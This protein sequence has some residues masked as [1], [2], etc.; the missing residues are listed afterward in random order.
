M[1]PQRK[2]ARSMRPSAEPYDIP[3]KYSKKQCEEMMPLYCHMSNMKNCGAEVGS[4]I[5]EFGINHDMTPA[6]EIL[7][8][9]LS[10]EDD[11][12][13]RDVIL[14]AIMFLGVSAGLEGEM[15]KWMDEMPVK[16]STPIKAIT[17][18]EDAMVF[19]DQLFTNEMYDDAMLIYNEYRKTDEY[20]AKRLE[21]CYAKSEH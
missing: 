20:A 1:P 10:T 15:H 7:Y 5:I 12:E 17:N 8:K 2:H 6:C 18:Y 3:V 4:S 13:Q 14:R 19:A 11:E 16:Y 9:S 21:E